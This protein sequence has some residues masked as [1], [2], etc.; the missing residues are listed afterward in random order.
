L[1]GFSSL[2]T[3]VGAVRAQTLLLNDPEP[4]EALITWTT[5]ARHAATV[6]NGT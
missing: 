1:S 4:P 3:W 6:A 5:C 2:A